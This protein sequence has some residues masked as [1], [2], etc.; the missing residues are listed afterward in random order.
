LKRKLKQL[1]LLPVLVMI[2]SLAAAG[3]TVD[4]AAAAD[5]VTVQIVGSNSI[6]LDDYALDMGTLTDAQQTND[7]TP[8]DGDKTPNALDAVLY[9]TLQKGYDSSSYGISYYTDYKSYFISKLA[10]VEANHP[11][12]WGTLA[13]SASGGYDG[14]ALN[15][16]TL[17]S[18]DTYI[19][20]FDA[21][22]DVGANYGNQSYASFRQKSV[23][24]NAGATINV[25]LITTGYDDNWN[26]VASSLAGAT[27]YADGPG[28]SDGTAVAVTDNNGQ[29]YIKFAAAGTYI[30]TLSSD[31]YTYTRCAVNVA[32]SNVTLYEAS[33]N[34]T[35]GTSNLSQAVMNLTDAS[36][37]SCSPCSISAGSYA[38][39]LT[40]GTY[41]YTA[42]AD[43]YESRSGTITVSS[44]TSQNINLIAKETY[45]VTITIAANE[46][47]TSVLIRNG[48]G[49]KQI[50]VS[51][52]GGVFQYYLSDGN[53][54]YTVCRDGYHSSFGSFT[55]N[56]AVKNL[57]VPALTDAAAGSAEWPA[58]RKSNDNIAVTAS[59]TAQGAWQAEEKWAVS[60][61]ELGAW[62]TLS[63]SNIIIY[64]GYLYA[65]TEHGL[66]KIDGST[67]QLL[68]TASLSANASYVSQIAYGGGKVFVTT[69]AGVDAFDALTMEK[70]WFCNDFDTFGS[71]YMCTT[72]LLY[73]NGTVYVGSYGCST[74]NSLGTYG[75]YSAIDASNG[76]IKWN[77][78]GEKD[79]DN[80]NTVCYGA[81]AVIEGN[82]LVFGSDD[83]YLRAI[84]L[85]DVGTNTYHSLLAAPLKLK[86]DGG[87][88][89]SVASA[90]GYLY[91]TAKSGY[92]YKV[93][94]S[95]AP[96]ALQLEQSAQFTATA[97]T[98][99][100][101]IYNGRVYVGANDGIYVLDADDLSEISRYT[102][103]APIQ[104]S[105]LLT[106]AYGGEA[107]AYFTVNSA[108]SEIIVL[109][110]DG[111]E[112]NYD[113]LYVPLH[114]Q[115]CLNSL[116]ADSGGVIYYSNDSGYVFAVKNN[117]R[118]QAGLTA[119][120]I[121]VSPAVIQSGT[122]TIYPAITV[123]DSSGTEVSTLVPGVYYLP[124]GDY[125]YS[126]SLSS[127]RTAAGTFT[128]T[129]QD[130]TAGSKN[131]AVVLTQDNGGGSVPATLTVTFILQDVA[132]AFSK[133]MTVNSGASVYNVFVKAMN[134]AGVSY[135]LN[136]GY[137]KTIDGLS[138]GDK[139]NNSGWMFKVNGSHPQVGIAN[140]Y[141]ES[142]DEIIFHFATD[143]TQEEDG[144]NWS[145][146]SSN[147]SKTEDN[148]PKIEE[149]G[150]GNAQTSAAFNDV[151]ENA[152]YF[153]A[154]NFVN[155]RG[156]FVGS[157]TNVFAP[158][159]LMT[160]AMFVMVLA[161]L[162]E[163]D[164][165]TFS[166]PAADTQNDAWYAA[167]VAWSASNGI[168]KGLGDGRFGPD[169]EITREQMC[170]LL[171]RYC[172]LAGIQLPA[173][174]VVG[175]FNDDSAISGWSRESVNMARQLGLIEGKEGNLFEPRGLLTRA[176]AATVFMRFAQKFIP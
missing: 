75:G 130:V 50:C 176:E 10:D 44:D 81:G 1:I 109:T 42:G 106:S 3:G 77:F 14:D 76:Q 4:K 23:A 93:S 30:L 100:P 45:L 53:Y 64:D 6:I 113:T 164:L 153:A 27:V 46:P 29:A 126:I 160:R 95:G 112:I 120:I 103:S 167:A 173:A 31:Y 125:S 35:D 154:V 8:D 21:N 146:G 86:V 39:R 36:G 98:S 104:S 141:V 26:T 138:E 73:D 152:W 32:G 37:L 25:A 105:A 59:L 123:K 41:D 66:S 158:D 124:V 5:Q 7:L 11:D 107:V 85:R 140:Y 166:S 163:T 142:G 68:K 131:I 135:T 33:I 94:L 150:A 137:V 88:R 155:E 91:F 157:S 139:G 70:V 74:Y 56:G 165:S 69:A 82:Y 132:D 18:G 65:A 168:I 61:G 114:S 149:K 127:Y 48:S 47:E 24:G 20:Y 119:V 102:T 128:I 38:Y 13:V 115:Y 171:I 148:D 101:L 170:V 52:A 79:K 63:A 175:T 51:A 62:G 92:V 83:E 90:G 89:S 116:V 57:E 159:R 17:T 143:Y 15:M 78:W 144:Q 110:D 117:L 12:Y 58:W 9:A 174:A 121:N 80:T 72:P 28:L 145:S 122:S 71:A 40:A 129:D 96:V 99:T 133:T 172:S 49:D 162:S 34:V 108:Q 169:E 161:R 134:T 97:S 22:T 67:G 54:T 87:I 151:S 43:G 84:D 16:H 55:V 136:D 147:D 2:F 60:L 118:P 19:V 156:L 111:T